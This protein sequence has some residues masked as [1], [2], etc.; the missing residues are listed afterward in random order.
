MKFG[1]TGGVAQLVGPTFRT[2]NGS[3]ALFC[4]RGAA[5]IGRGRR[6]MAA[7]ARVGQEAANAKPLSHKE[8][9]PFCSLLLCCVAP[10]DT[11]IG[12]VQA[13]GGAGR[14]CVRADACDFGATPPR[15][16]SMSIFRLVEVPRAALEGALALGPQGDLGA[17]PRAK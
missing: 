13:R 14:G 11:C 4:F 9:P 16:A 1:S 3:W 5:F 10:G 2:K 15:S 7:G 17:A 8:P 12:E 6:A